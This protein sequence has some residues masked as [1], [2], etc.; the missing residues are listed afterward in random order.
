MEYSVSLFSISDGTFGSCFYFGTGF[1]GFT[2]CV[3]PIL[4][5]QKTITNGL[6]ISV[7]V[8]KSELVNSYFLKREFIEWL[9][10]FVDAEGNFNI[11]ITGLNNK[12]YKNAQ[13]TLQIG[14]HADDKKVLEYIQ[15]NLKCGHISSSQNR[16]NF[17]VNDKLSLIYIILPIFNSVNLNSSKYHHFIVFEKAL[18][19]VKR[20]D[21][22]NKLGKMQRI[23][24]QKQMQEMSGA[25]IPPTISKKINIT[26]DWLAGFVD[27]DGTFSTNK[28]KPRFKLENHIKE[29][30][31]YNKIKDYLATGNLTIGFVRPGREHRSVTV[32]LEVN[33]IKQLKEIIIPIMHHRLKTIKRMDFK[34]WLHLINIYYMGYHV[35]P[36]GKA[37]FNLIKLVMNKYRLTSNAHLLKNLPLISEDIIESKLIELYKINSPYVLQ[38]GIRYIRDTDQLVPDLNSITV[39]HNNIKTVY[40]NISD[41]SKK[42]NIGRKTIKNCLV[43]GKSYKGYTFSFI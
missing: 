39:D 37:I 25:W 24:F 40:L 6:H 5:E 3:A 36:E 26:K 33:K 10:G 14:L 43:T 2:L 41:C 7:A 35:L 18:N 31:L 27:G 34:M 42:L 30:E 32:S 1:H 12:T 16:V 19:L 13:F 17:F 38:D 9:V 21:H 4:N 20:N 8:K 15:E 29:L 23:N 28:C 22:L 11:K